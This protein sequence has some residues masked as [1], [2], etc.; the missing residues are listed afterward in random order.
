M[1]QNNTSS[2][3]LNCKANYIGIHVCTIPY[4]PFVTPSYPLINNQPIIQYGWI[5]P[6]C[7]KGNAPWLP[8]CGSCPTVTS[9]ATTIGSSGPMETGRNTN[10]K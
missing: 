1:N 10:G 5:C 2:Y 3:C 4:N 8:T 6:K 7:N 9:V